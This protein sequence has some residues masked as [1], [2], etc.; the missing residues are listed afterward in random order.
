MAAA[1]PIGGIRVELRDGGG[2]AVIGLSV[3]MIPVLPVIACAI[4]SAT[5]LPDPVQTMIAEVI[6]APKVA[7]RRST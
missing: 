1:P 6:C 4:R 5:S 7:V 3:A 2:V